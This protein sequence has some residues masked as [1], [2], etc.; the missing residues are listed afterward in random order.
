MGITKGKPVSKR[1]ADNLRVLM[2]LYFAQRDIAAPADKRL[3]ELGY[4]RAHH[5]VLTFIGL[6]PGMT[7]NEL[8]RILR[9]ANQSLNRVLGP[10]VKQGFIEQKNDREDLR[11]RRLYLTR[12]GEDLANRGLDVQFQL[13]EAAIRGAG[14]E[15]YSGFV[16]FSR[17][18]M[19]EQDRELLTKLVD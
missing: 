7:V 11:C 16:A 1:R 19:D 12:K 9:I 2:C 14:I 10:L 4:G 17:A 13:I 8:G 5:R 18:L 3:A 15:A 6:N